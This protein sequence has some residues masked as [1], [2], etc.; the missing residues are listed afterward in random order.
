MDPVTQGSLGAIA[1]QSLAKKNELKWA[2]IIGWLAGMAPDLDVLIRSDIDP[3]VFY[4]YHRHFTHSLL[5]IPLGSLIVSLFLHL[6][7]KK[8]ISFKKNYFFSFLGYGTHGL[9]DACTSYGTLLLW[10]FSNYR[11]AWNNISIV[12]PLFTFPLITFIVLA[13]R[14]KSNKYARYAVFYALFYLSLG[15]V[16][17][18]R[19]ESLG[20]K[21]AQAEGHNPLRLTARPSLGNLYLWRVVYEHQGYFYSYAV[22]VGFNPNWEEGEKIQ[23]LDLKRDYPWVREGSQHAIDIEKFKW[24]SV[25]YLA[26]HPDDPQSIGDIRFSLSPDSMYPLW[27]IQLKKGKDNEHVKNINFRMKS[28]KLRKRFLELLFNK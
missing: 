28:L 4:L 6:F 7:L 10:P 20:H 2:F 17:A 1:S 25:D 24:F 12:D 3:M 15:V 23:K 13:L 16:Q 27:G 21:I 11:F 5:F 9:L 14:G 26:V 8:K 22:R 18:N 19:A